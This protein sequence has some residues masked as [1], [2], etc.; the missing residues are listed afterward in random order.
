MIGLSFDR[1]L[2]SFALHLTVEP[3]VYMGLRQVS[4]VYYEMVLDGY[5]QSLR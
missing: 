3:I 2:I 4:E 5:Y 1:F